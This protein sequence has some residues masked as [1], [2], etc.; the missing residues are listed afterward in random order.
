MPPKYAQFRK[1]TE[2]RKSKGWLKCLIA[3]TVENGVI[4]SAGA[5][6]HFA[7]Y[8]AMPNTLIHIPV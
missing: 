2:R 5:V 7:L 8:I 6:L 4:T 3:H 1:N